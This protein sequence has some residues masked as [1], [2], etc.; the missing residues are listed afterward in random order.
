MF[1][2]FGWPELAAFKVL[3]WMKSILNVPALEQIRFPF[4]VAEWIDPQVFEQLYQLYAE[5]PG[6]E[7]WSDETIESTLQQIRF[8]WDAGFFENKDSAL[9]ILNQTEEMIR[10]MAR[11]AETGQKIG[12]KG[13]STGAPP[14]MYLCD[15]MNGNNAI[16]LETGDSA[17]SVIG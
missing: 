12:Y 6:T 17:C 3:Y 8:Y 7:I 4:D 2:H 10:R 9:V 15:L 16:Y 1:Y 5:I 14:K 11:Q 13:A